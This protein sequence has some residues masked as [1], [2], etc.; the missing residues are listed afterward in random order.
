MLDQALPSEL[1]VLLPATDNSSENQLRQIATNSERLEAL[2]T[3][4]GSTY[5]LTT[6]R[7]IVCIEG[8]PA[9]ARARADLQLFTRIYPRS[10]AFTFVPSKGKG[11]VIQTVS[12]LRNH[13]PETVYK[14]KVRG[15]VDADQGGILPDGVLSLPVCM[16]ENLLIDP[17][18]LF[19]FLSSR[20]ISD[21]A[22]PSDVSADLQKI[23]AA[24]RDS[25]ISLR[26][27]RRLK[28]HTARFSGKDLPTVKQN[29]KSEIEKVA[30]LLPTDEALEKIIAECTSEVD[31]ILSDNTAAE[32]FRGKQMLDEFFHKHL[33]NANI[34]KDE[35]YLA[36][37][38]DIG[39]NGTVA[40]RLDPIFDSLVQ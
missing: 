14:I 21:F 13:L 25:E 36:L 35:F 2:R 5:F 23:S 26:V 18:A 1:Y 30:N 24:M 16:I 27:Q 17:S 6:G 33:N 12:S 28:A 22:S 10:T 19:R 29:H 8:E 9:I 15:L 37:A 32:K 3:L 7:V 4:T 39:K 38:D 40:P 11:N 31:Q 20:S 34:S